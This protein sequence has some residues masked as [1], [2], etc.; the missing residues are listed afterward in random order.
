MNINSNQFFDLLGEA[1]SSYLAAAYKSMNEKPAR[2]W[3]RP[4]LI[5]ACLTLVLIAIPVGILI[6]NHTTKPTVPV[7]D[8]TTTT[9]TVP[10]ATTPP[11]TTEAHKAS[12]LDIPGAT[13]FASGA[14][15]GAEND[16]SMLS[17]SALTDRFRLCSL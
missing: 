11:E 8:P 14:R 3:F 5:A 9:A 17:F 4:A 1:D 6:G 2:A 12:V 16:Q 15:E 10:P 7:I 13:L